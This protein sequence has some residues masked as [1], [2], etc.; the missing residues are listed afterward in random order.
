M[1][2]VREVSDHYGRSGIEATI[3][4]ILRTDGKDPDRLK[5]SD[6]TGADEL[7]LGW[8]KATVE[9]GKSMGL[10]PGTKVLDVGSG[11]GGPA[12]YFAEAHGCEVV[13]VDVTA[14]YVDA[15]NGLSRRCGLAD[16]VSF[17]EADAT[18]LSFADASFDAATLIH[19]GMN[20]ADKDK[21]FAEVRRILKPEGRFGVYEIMRMDDGEIPYPMPWAATSRTSFVEPPQTYRTLLQENGFE[22][23]SEQDRRDLTLEMAAEMRENV[24]RNGPPPLGLHIVMGPGTPERLANVIATLQRGTIAPVE[25]VCRPV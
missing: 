14:E 24:A 19:V 20:I 4:D 2:I 1:D 17:E 3:V 8:H 16:R 23:E 10:A 21:L 13:G 15:A 9:L 11:I 5:A 6:L 22:I 12:R 25:M 7:H 18:S